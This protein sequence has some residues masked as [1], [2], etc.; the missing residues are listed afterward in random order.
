MPQLGQALLQ[1]GAVQLLQ[2]G[3]VIT[4][5]GKNYYKL[6]HKN[7]KFLTFLLDPNFLNKI[8]AP[9]KKIVLRDTLLAIHFI[10]QFYCVFCIFS[11]CI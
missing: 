9:W 4:N 1:T 10:L 2:I 5:Q 7:C 6:G 8:S 3:A 11:S